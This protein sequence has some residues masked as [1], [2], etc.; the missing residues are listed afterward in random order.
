MKQFETMK[1]LGSTKNKLTEDKNC[2]NMPYVKVVEVVL[3][4]I[5]STMINQILSTWFKSLI[6][7]LPLNHLA[8]Y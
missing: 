3:I 5:F 4:V 1:L 6:H 8:N 7:L 2:E